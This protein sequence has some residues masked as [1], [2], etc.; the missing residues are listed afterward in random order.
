[1]ESYVIFMKSNKDLQKSELSFVLAI[2]TV[3]TFPSHQH[4]SKNYTHSHNTYCII[5]IQTIRVL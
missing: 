1:M 4:S 3:N 5:M 2:I